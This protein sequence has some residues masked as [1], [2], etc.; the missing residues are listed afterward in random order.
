MHEFQ[1]VLLL[2]GELS[3]AELVRTAR[4]YSQPPIVFDRYEGMDRPPWGNSPPRNMWTGAE[5]RARQDGRMAHLDD[6]GPTNPEENPLTAETGA[7]ETEPP[8]A[9]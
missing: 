6:R 4:E 2:D 3:D 5:Q 9:A 8:D 7:T 1:F